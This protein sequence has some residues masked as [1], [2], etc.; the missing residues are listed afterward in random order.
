MLP[1]Y[2]PFC[3][4][5]FNLAAK[6][7]KKNHVK[8]D[9]SLGTIL[10]ELK[11]FTEGAVAARR[12]FQRIDRVP[13]INAEE[14]EGQ[15]LDAIV[16]EIHFDQVKFT[17][18]SRPDSLVLNSFNLKIEA[19]QTL[20]LV[21][22]SGCGKSTA[23]SLIQ[24]FYDADEGVVKIDG[25]DIKTLNLKWLRNKMGLVSQDHALFGTS[26]RENIKFGKLDATNDEIMAAAMA[27]NAHNFIMQLPQGY[28]TNVGARG[29]LLSGGQKQR[30][31]IARA[32]VKNPIILLL[33]EAT[34]ALDSESESVVQNALDQASIG[35]TT[36]VKINAE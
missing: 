36:L 11:H 26:I 5:L 19:G 25:L 8:C 23:I 13:R 10:P 18:P 12:I 9:R 21:G 1:N 31:A 22:A 7:I 20:A 17:Y 3:H 27:A 29:G 34:S 30:I 24:R 14:I 33:D 4:I 35:R 28:E 32:I 16:G 15:V 6:F 2:I